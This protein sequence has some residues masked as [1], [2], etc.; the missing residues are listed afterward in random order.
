MIH[1]GHSCL[2]N[3]TIEERCANKHMQETSWV[4]RHGRKRKSTVKRGIKSPLLLL[5]VFFLYLDFRVLKVFSSLNDYM[6]VWAKELWMLTMRCWKS[7]GSPN[8]PS[9]DLNT[10]GHKKRMRISTRCQTKVT[11]FTYEKTARIGK[12]FWKNFWHEML[13]VHFGLV[14]PKHGVLGDA[15]HHN[16]TSHWKL[17]CQQGRVKELT[18]VALNNEAQSIC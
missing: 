1:G 15:I 8:L 10:F 17:C 7:I 13:V 2:W 16:H 9:R 12:H 14:P 11:F 4:R 5:Q 3:Y 18:N 6:I